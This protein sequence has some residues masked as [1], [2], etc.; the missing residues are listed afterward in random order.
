MTG[1][2][3]LRRLTD[4]DRATLQALL[5]ADPGYTRRVSGAD[6]APDEAAELLTSRPP[7]L[8]AE[9]KVVLGAFDDDGLAVVVDVLRGWPEPTTALVGLLQVHA[10][11]KRQGAGRRAHE[12][13]VDL[14][15][16]W[17]EIRTLRAAIVATNAAEA[18]PFWS[19]LGYRPTG[20]PQPFQAG[21]TV[22]EVTGWTR[23]VGSVAPWRP[24]PS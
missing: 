21:A 9:H 11:R 20:R 16:T 23:P 1:E 18:E 2:L 7:G 19:A 13:L 6:P 4:D 14:V 10:N 15:R 12:L 3:Q 5:E 17:P 22:T 8:P 24:E